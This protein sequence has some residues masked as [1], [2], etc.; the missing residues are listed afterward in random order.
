[1]N[2]SH[3]RLPGRD[4]GRVAPADV[5]VG[6]RGQLG[7]GGLDGR[8]GVDRAQRRGDALAVVVGHEPHR[9]ADQVDRAGLHRGLRP[10]RFDGLGEA[11][12]AVAAHDQHVADPAFGAPVTF[13]DGIEVRAEAPRVYRTKNGYGPSVPKQVLQVPITATNRSSRPFEPPKVRWTATFNGQPDTANLALSEPPE[14]TLAGGVL[15]PGQSQSF[16][17]LYP[18]P[19]QPADLVLTAQEITAPGQLSG[20]PVYYR[21]PT[22]TAAPATSSRAPSS[23]RATTR[24]ATP[25]TTR[26]RSSTADT[27]AG[28]GGR[29]V[30]RGVF[31]PSC[32]EY[33]GYLDPGKAAGRAPSSG[34]IQ[35][36]YACE[37][38]L[39][40]ASQC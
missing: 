15:L 39:I 35:T 20:A 24:A 8:G 27:S 14:V 11:P 10:G 26:S 1:M 13:P 9:R 16:D 6:E 4:R 23:T 22:P 31:N 2:R 32:S 18:V 40:P 34:D 29:A 12:Q 28:C 33:Q 17:Q 37:K 21:G 7:L 19:A 5:G 30:A 38:G 36:Q 25:S 3:A